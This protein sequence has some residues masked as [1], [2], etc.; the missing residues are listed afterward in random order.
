MI[1]AC[2]TQHYL[3]ITKP[4]QGPPTPW[5]NQA[6]KFS[7]EKKSNI[8]LDNKVNSEGKTPFGL[9]LPFRLTLPG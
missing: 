3:Q 9:P 8:S 1:K 7:K 6:D 5:P 4:T 2:L